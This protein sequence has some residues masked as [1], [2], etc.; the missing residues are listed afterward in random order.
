MPLDDFD[1]ESYTKEDYDTSKFSDSGISSFQWEEVS[2]EQVEYGYYAHYTEGGDELG[3]FSVAPGQFVES[4]RKKGINE[5]SIKK[6]HKDLRIF[7]RVYLLE[8]GIPIEAAN[9]YCPLPIRGSSVESDEGLFWEIIGTNRAK[10]IAHFY[11]KGISP[12][13]ALRIV[14]GYDERFEGMAYDIILADCLP[15]T[16]NQYPDWCGEQEVYCLTS[17]G[18]GPKEAALFPEDTDVG[19]ISSLAELNFHCSRY[20]PKQLECLVEPFVM[21]AESFWNEILN[22]FVKVVGTGAAGVV[23][24]FDRE[25]GEISALKFSRDISEEAKLL[26]RVSSKNV[27]SMENLGIP[28][29]YDE[30]LSFEFTGVRG[31]KEK[32]PAHKLSEL[33]GKL[34]VELEFLRGETLSQLLD[35]KKQVFTPEQTLEYGGDI[36]NGLCDLKASGIYHRDLWLGNVMIS[37]YENYETDPPETEKKAIIIDLGIS[38]DDP[39]EGPKDNRRYGGENDLQ[40]LGQIMYKMV[41]GKHIFNPTIDKST[42]LIPDEVKAARERAYSRGTLLNKRLLQVEKEVADGGV[43]KIIEHCLRAKGTDQDYQTLQKMFNDCAKCHKLK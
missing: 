9:E 19:T 26:Q 12:E 24:M 8:Q 14:E 40:S 43:T 39:K 32:H 34:F 29:H 41:T 18:A 7:E 30:D 3:T 17:I 25:W 2:P 28:S 27:V 4:L 5:E 6:F 31:M 22:D 10:C 16:A 38:T 1:G 42:H 37:E 15:E 33:E 36:F 13:E 11:E 21:I 23:V 35:K 20:T